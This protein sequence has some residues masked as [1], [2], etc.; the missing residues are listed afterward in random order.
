MKLENILVDKEGHIKMS[1]FGIA[2]SRL[3]GVNRMTTFCGTPQYTSPEV[4]KYFCL[5]S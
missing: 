2:K 4:S 5:M 3:L 1:D